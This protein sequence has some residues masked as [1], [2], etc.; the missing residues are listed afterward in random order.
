MNTNFC[1]T[2]AA[3]AVT[4]G[5]FNEEFYYKVPQTKNDKGWENIIQETYKY[6]PPENLPGYKFIH[7]IVIKVSSLVLKN[8]KGET[9]NPARAT[10]ASRDSKG[11]FEKGINVKCLPPKVVRREKNHNLF[12]GF[13]RKEYFDELGYKYWVYDVYEDDGQTTDFMLDEE[14]KFDDNALSDNGEFTNS[15][16]TKQDY[17]CAAMDKI[18]KYG[19]DKTKLK[20]WF[21]N[22]IKHT[23]TE[24][25][26]NDY[27][28]DAFRRDAAKGRIE[29]FREAEIKQ[30]LKKQNLEN[31]TVINTNGAEKGN[32]AR[33]LKVL[34]KLM[35]GYCDSMGQTQEIGL[36]NTFTSTWDTTDMANDAMVKLAE[37]FIGKILRF[38]AAHSY[39]K[40]TPWKV[41][42]RIT[43]RKGEGGDE[44]LG[45]FVEYPEKKVTKPLSEDDIVDFTPIAD[46]LQVEELYT[47]QG[48]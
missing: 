26:V 22:G 10:N 3:P 32:D 15:P 23:L 39:F 1:S 24:N 41:T 21:D 7:R 8:K 35:D 13:G 27:V 42:K 36:H 45:V 31:L 6:A 9:Q 5:F 38:S 34:M 20:S 14:D 17:V 4:K 28:A 33:L 44:E 43:Q 11:S 37:S 48:S 46:S 18:S 2:A 12:G 16:P 29:W 30:Q 19:W 40:T 47:E 25:Q